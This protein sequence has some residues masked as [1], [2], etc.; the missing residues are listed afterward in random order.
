MASEKKLPSRI[1]RPGVNTCR[2]VDVDVLRNRVGPE[3]KSSTPETKPAGI[4]M[5]KLGTGT[6]YRDALPTPLPVS[7]PPEPIKR[8]RPPPPSST[9]PGH[10]NGHV[11]SS[12]TPPPPHA[13]NKTSTPVPSPNRGQPGKQPASTDSPTKL[14]PAADSPA[15][16]KPNVPLR[17]NRPPVS[18]NSPAKKDAPVAQLAK[19]QP[20]KEE[21]KE[22]EAEDDEQTS[23]LSPRGKMTAT[24]KQKLAAARGLLSQGT[25]AIEVEP[26]PTV[27]PRDDDV[28]EKEEEVEEEEVKERQ[29]SPR[30]ATREEFWVEAIETWKGKKAKNELSFKKGNRIRVI[31]KNDEDGLFYGYI[32]TKKKGWFPSFYVVVCN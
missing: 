29:P 27:P 4:G 32:G 10:A 28:H 9:P 23:T 19:E 5:V 7:I 6:L 2:N 8:A 18:T 20:K 17:S 15:K 3:I 11:L 24:Q 14:K 22:E 12:R 16:V 1:A 31:E 30:K 26:P 25:P 13:P 21:P